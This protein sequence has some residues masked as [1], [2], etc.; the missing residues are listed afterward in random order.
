MRA[1]VIPIALAIAL[2]GCFAAANAQSGSADYTAL[3]EDADGKVKRCGIEYFGQFG[4]DGAGHDLVFK[5]SSGT[6]V[7]N[8]NFAVVYFSVAGVRITGKETG[9]RIKVDDAAIEA[10]DL[11]TRGSSMKRP[12]GAADAFIVTSLS[13]DEMLPL[14]LFMANGSRLSVRLAEEKSERNFALPRA[15]DDTAK[16]ISGCFDRMAKLL[17]AA[18]ESPKAKDK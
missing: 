4:K 3:V 12:S 5:V 15:S 9:E 14:P 2:S 7:M 18:A 10:G 13:Q 8:G 1:P 6:E 16:K 11:K 17:A